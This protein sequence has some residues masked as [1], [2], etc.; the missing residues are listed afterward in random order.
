M[1][2]SNPHQT[3]STRPLKTFV[4]K[5]DKSYLTN[6][7]QDVEEFVNHLLSK[8][9]ILKE[10]TKFSVHSTFRCMN[11]ETITNNIDEMNIRYENLHQSS[12]FKILTTTENLPPIEKN[13]N[14]CQKATNH[15]NI[16]TINELP[17]VLI[18]SLKR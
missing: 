4:G 12:I 16:E 14:Y 5:S 18:I 10:L 2:I 9:N 11:C 7:Q 17:D 3:Q 13:C 8:C 1:I 15:I 6:R